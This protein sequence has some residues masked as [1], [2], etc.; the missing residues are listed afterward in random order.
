M[1][2]TKR[3]NGIYM[4][5]LKVPEDVRH[6]L[7]KARLTKS[8]K[9]RD[10]RI[11]QQEAGT[12]LAKW[13][14]QIRL[15]R[16]EP[17]AILEELAIARARIDRE[18]EDP[19]IKVDEWG[20]LPTE[21]AI[22]AMGLTNEDWL[23]S[24][25]PSVADRYCD[26]LWGDGIPLPQFM[27]GFIRDRYAKHRTQT[28][29][30]RYILEAT[31]FTPT[32]SH[33]TRENA[34][35]WVRTEAQKPEAERRAL[36]TMQKAAGFLSEYVVWLQHQRLLSDSIANPF[37]DISWP[38]GLAQKTSY[39]PL[40]LDELVMLREAA[41][42]ARD[43]ELVAYM[44]VARLTGMRLAEV[45]ALSH[46]S[47]E[48]V[49]GI[50]CFRV[51]DDAKT[52]KSAGRLVPIAPALRQLVDLN[53]FDFGRRENAVGKRFGRL[54]QKTLADG[55]NRAKCFH[56]IRKWVVTELER[57]GVAETIAADL[58]GHEKQTL[59][60]GVYSGGSALK[61]LGM[62]V[63]ELEQAAGGLGLEAKNNVAPFRRKN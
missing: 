53:S 58:V 47:V 9:T 41:V 15:A 38:K 13:D 54:K 36:K 52:A 39:A 4:A 51:K 1:N 27:E 11:A 59:T 22:E 21:S 56:S 12:V 31:L 49:D 61:Q 18:K 28:E 20:Y 23:E 62:A 17:D 19:S 43:T 35:A 16:E 44:D 42:A 46:R 6:I 24:L 37:K 3:S 25:P 40:S 55:G 50:E 48:T 29:A 63:A 26:V 57:A 10:K 7:G 34:R 32:L 60:Y 33:L 30:R 2:I 8:L 5:D 45:G 14:R